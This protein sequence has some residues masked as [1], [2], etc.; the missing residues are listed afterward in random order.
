MTQTKLDAKPNPRSQ[1]IQSKSEYYMESQGQ[2]KDT[3]VTQKDLKKWIT[4][5]DR[6]ISSNQKQNE[7]VFRGKVEKSLKSPDEVIPA[8]DT[9]TDDSDCKV[10]TI[11]D[12]GEIFATVV[13]TDSSRATVV[14]PLTKSEYQNLKETRKLELTD[15]SRD[16]EKRVPTIKGQ[17]EAQTLEKTIDQNL[18]SDYDNFRRPLNGKES[19]ADFLATTTDGKQGELHIQRMKP[20]AFKYQSFDTQIERIKSG[21]QADGQRAT[22][23]YKSVCDLSELQDPA[24]QPK[25]YN[26]IVGDLSPQ[27][28]DHTVFVF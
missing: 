5:K 6:E 25:A 4:D 22:T 14:T 20:D 24:L 19:K 12:D 7:K 28:R 2:E 18:V 23:D 16:T 17:L 15:L 10:F 8:K 26:D 21:I 11:K 13:D 3:L 27:E 9:H 1:R